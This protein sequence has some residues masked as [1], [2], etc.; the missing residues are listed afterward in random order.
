MHLVRKVQT[1]VG[2]GV[3]L[4]DKTEESEDF[5]R[6]EKYF[7]ANSDATEKLVKELTPESA[8]GAFAFVKDKMGKDSIGKTAETKRGELFIGLGTE[9]KSSAIHDTPYGEA[10]IHLGEF[11]CKIG[12]VHQQHDISI[13]ESS[14]GPLRIFNENILKDIHRLAK[15]YNEKRQDFDSAQRAHKKKPDGKT[16]VNLD[17]KTKLYQEAKNQYLDKIATL[18]Q[19]EAEQVGQMAEYCRAQSEF[20]QSIT[21][22]WQEAASDLHRVQERASSTNFGSS[23]G[24]GNSSSSGYSSGGGSISPR[25]SAPAV[26]GGG[27]RP[28][29]PAPIRPVSLPQ[30]RGLYDFD[31]Q[32]PTEL[33]FRKGDVIL[34]KKQVNQD[35]IE[36][37][38]NGR[39][40]LLPANYVEML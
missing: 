5:K 23:Y 38:L 20:Y 33:S 21:G 30:C 17:T 34:I 15:N 4:Y 2:E 35:W 12:E 32:A 18:P 10:M 8:T 29:P 40:G 7:Q 13:I 25:G 26:P 16:Q 11:L 28:P 1:T 24:S 6:Q 3:G 37:E 14:V 39:V 22:M 9:L 31:A 27:V 36:G 19:A